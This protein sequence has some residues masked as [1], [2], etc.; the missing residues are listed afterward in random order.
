MLNANFKS[1]KYNFL[2]NVKITINVQFKIKFE[3]KC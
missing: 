3:V 1:L 2:D